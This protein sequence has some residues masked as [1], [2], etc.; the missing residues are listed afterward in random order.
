MSELGAYCRSL[1]RMNTIVFLSAFVYCSQ[2]Q[3]H[4]LALPADTGEETKAVKAF[5]EF[6]SRPPCVKELRFTRFQRN[7]L[8]PYSYVAAI[9]GGDFFLM[10]CAPGQGTLL[11]ISFTNSAPRGFFVGLHGDKRWMIGG[12]S[13]TEAS[14]PTNA[15]DPLAANVMVGAD[16]IKVVLAMGCWI[17]EPGTAVWNG[18]RFR[19]NA[20]ALIRNSSLNAVSVDGEILVRNGVVAELAILAPQSQHFLFE[21]WETNSLPSGIPNKIIWGESDTKFSHKY[22]IEKIELVDQIQ[23]PAYFEPYRHVDP[24]LLK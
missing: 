24:I 15:T 17:Y 19:A 21:Y 14:F 3:S 10:P 2:P 5:K 11:P 8:P 1:M 20:T 7:P 13:I 9:C 18:N 23:D 4:V 6:L 12:L 22:V 16:S